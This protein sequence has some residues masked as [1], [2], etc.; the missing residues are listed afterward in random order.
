MGIF[1][2]EGWNIWWL[3]FGVAFSGFSLVK[4]VT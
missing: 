4:I 1:I 3:L 2:V